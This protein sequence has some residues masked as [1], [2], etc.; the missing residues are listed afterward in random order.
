[1]S[2]PLKNLTITAVAVNGKSSGL[3]SYGNYLLNDQAESHKN[4]TI[5]PIVGDMNNFISH[6]ANE[7]VKIDLKNGRGKG[8]RPIQSYAVSFNLTLPPNTVRPT[9]QQWKAIMLDVMRAVKKEIPGLT[10]Q[11]FFI[12]VHDQ[13]NP[14]ANLL[15]S[16]IINGE[17]CRKLDQQKVLH[18][19]KQVYS[20]SVF[21]H[22]G[23][24]YRTY[25]PVEP[26]R[27]KRKKKWQ[28][29][30]DKEKQKFYTQVENLLN[31][32]AEGNYIRTKSTENRI[33]KTVEATG[34]EAYEEDF[35]KLIESAN[36][37]GNQDLQRSIK[38]ISEKS[39]TKDKP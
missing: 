17:R 6:A 13:E 15:I 10:K 29:E 34:W 32:I 14:H 21:N 35:K 20:M 26:N 39:K 5:I 4:T 37:G 38:N 27:G 24:D 18:T 33:I 30:R 11:D 2:E 9:P 12:N 8:G 31:Y 36:M 23:F 22:T 1:M 7:A 3:I 16:K 19:M 25:I 28:T